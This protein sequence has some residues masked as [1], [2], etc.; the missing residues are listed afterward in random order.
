MFSVTKTVE[1]ARN[2]PSMNFL[3]SGI[4][5]RVIQPLRY[6]CIL[7]KILQKDIII[8]S[9]RAYSHEVPLIV[10]YEVEG[11]AL[12]LDVAPKFKM[13]L[14]P[15]RLDLGRSWRILRSIPKGGPPRSLS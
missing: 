15:S 13:K 3:T 11:K 8:G 1:P 7:R 6:I 14:V 10:F 4:P 9:S 5:T 12:A 2:V